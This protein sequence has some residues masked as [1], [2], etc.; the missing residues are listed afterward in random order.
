[1]VYKKNP[2][3]MNF[4]SSTITSKEIQ[5]ICDA[6]MNYNMP[7][8]VYRINEIYSSFTGAFRRI[9]LNLELCGKIV[10]RAF[11]WS[12]TLLNIKELI[13]IT[14]VHYNM[15]PIDNE[16]HR[17]Y[18]SFIGGTQKYSVKGLTMIDIPRSQFQAAVCFLSFYFITGCV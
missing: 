13:W 5:L 12:Y 10:W 6:E 18:R 4:I 3:A 7:T 1:M 11:E 15:F 2:F 14:E 17:N 8:A 16:V 9:A